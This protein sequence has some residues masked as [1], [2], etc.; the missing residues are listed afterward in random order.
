MY[1][2][3]KLADQVVAALRQWPELGQ[4]VCRTVIPRQVKLSEAPSFGQPITTFES[5]GRGAS[6]YRSLA[7][8]VVNG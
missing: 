5:S 7:Q 8:E 6:A 2:R 1:A 4:I 3:S